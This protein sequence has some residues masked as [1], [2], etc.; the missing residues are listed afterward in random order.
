VDYTAGLYAVAKIKKIPSLPLPEI[1]PGHSA[2][3]SVTILTELPLF[4]VG[5]KHH[6]K[7]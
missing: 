4:L 3:S 5:Y 1:D 2:R 6:A 7:Q